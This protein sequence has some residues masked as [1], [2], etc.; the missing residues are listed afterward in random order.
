MPLITPANK[1]LWLAGL[2]TLF[3]GVLAGR[4]WLAEARWRSPLYCFATPQQVWSAAPR[5]DAWTPVCPQSTTYRREVRQ[6]DSRV[7]QFRLP[8]W[9]P[10]AVLQVLREAGYVQLEDEL[11]GA[12]HYSAFIGK[13]VAG[14]LSYTALKEGSDTLITVSG[15]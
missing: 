6:G 2:L 14:E 7:E 9:Q 15:R 4:Q 10:R 13:S 8:G 5:P 12:D 3:L 11:E 1:F